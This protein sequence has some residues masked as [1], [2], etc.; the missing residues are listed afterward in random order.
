MAAKKPV[1]HLVPLNIPAVPLGTGFALFLEV[2]MPK[3][4]CYKCIAVFI[5]FFPLAALALMAE[6][7]RPRPASSIW[8]SAFFPVAIVA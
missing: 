8:T 7:I 3:I 6:R 5:A 1:E 4:P 2:L